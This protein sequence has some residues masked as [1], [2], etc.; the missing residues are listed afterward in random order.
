MAKRGRKSYSESESQR[1]KLYEAYKKQY[2]ALYNKYGGNLTAELD[3]EQ[4]DLMYKV[5]RE[6]GVNQNVV[7]SMVK[8]QQNVTGDQARAWLK[9]AKKKKINIK[10]RDFLSGNTKSEEFWRY[11]DDHGGFRQALYVDDDDL[12]DV[13]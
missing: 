13:A 2:K 10:L 6:A 12:E 5:Y 8:D 9:L 7:R 1:Q 3:K 4:F 11:I